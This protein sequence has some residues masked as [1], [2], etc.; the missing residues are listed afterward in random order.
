VRLPLMHPA[1]SKAV[2]ASI[3]YSL[4]GSLPRGALDHPA[5]GRGGPDAEAWPAWGG[6][7]VVAGVDIGLLEGR[8]A[9]AAATGR[10]SSITAESSRSGPTARNS[11]ELPR[12]ARPSQARV[13][14]VL[15]GGAVS[16][17]PADLEVQA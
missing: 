11:P 8:Y 9:R 17:V 1:C 15:R 6:G 10:A 16:R 7:I 13:A 5:A 12:P 3:P 14:V 2:L 4:P